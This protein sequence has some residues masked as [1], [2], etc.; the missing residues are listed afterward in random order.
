MITVAYVT[1]ND[2][3]HFSWFAYNSE[4]EHL[5]DKAIGLYFDGD[6]DI[7]RMDPSEALEEYSQED[8]PTTVLYGTIERFYY[9]S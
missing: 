7:E 3:D 2:S 4:E 9:G 6:V 5:L 1:S 8:V